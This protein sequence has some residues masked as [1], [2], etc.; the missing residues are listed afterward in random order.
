MSTPSFQHFFMRERP[1]ARDGA[2]PLAQLALHRMYRRCTI[3][4]ARKETEN[5]VK[6]IA[7]HGYGI[8]PRGLAVGAPLRGYRALTRGEAGPWAFFAGQASARRAEPRKRLP[9]R[10]TQPKRKGKRGG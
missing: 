9:A 10:S 2:D 8:T 7:T 4:S 1:L 3:S 6:L 5:F